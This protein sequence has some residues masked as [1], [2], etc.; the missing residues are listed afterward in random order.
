MDLPPEELLQ[1]LREGKIYIPEQAVRAMENFFEAG[2]L[3]A[4]R[5]I[6]LRRAANR[7]D[8]QMREY[9]QTYPTAGLWPVTERLLVCISGSP[10]SER[11]I[12]TARRLAEELK[13]EWYALYV[14][15]AGNDKLTQEN[16]ERIWR[17]LRLAESLGAKEVTTL[18]ADSAPDAVIDYAR[19]NKITKVLVGRPTRARWREWLRGSFVDQVLRRSKEIDVTSSARKWEKKK[20]PSPRNQ[21]E[22]PGEVISPVCFWLPEQPSSVKLPSNSCRRPT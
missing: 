5:E 4:L 9:L 8:E 1:R 18:T 3:I 11:L 19:K 7:V 21:P 22:Y 10:N 12:R 2:N 15:T 13:T 14:E 16:R 17:E 6:T 20:K